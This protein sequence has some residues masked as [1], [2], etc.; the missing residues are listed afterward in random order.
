LGELVDTTT[1]ADLERHARI[2]AIESGQPEPDE[3][4]RAIAVLLPL[5]LPTGSSQG[6]DPLTEVAEML[7]SAMSDEHRAFLEAAR[8][9]PDEVRETL[10]Q[11]VQAAADGVSDEGPSS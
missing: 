1:A 2:L 7:G 4:R 11:Y 8:V 3:V 5:E 6:R 10:R 9:G